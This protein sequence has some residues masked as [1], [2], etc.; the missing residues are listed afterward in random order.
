MRCP[1]LVSRNEE[2]TRL[3]DALALPGSGRGGVWVVR[4]E[5]GVGKSRLAGELLDEARSAGLAVL[6]GRAVRAATPVPLRPLGEALLAWLRAGAV[7]DDPSLA[8]FLPALGRLAPQLRTTAD[9]GEPS[10]VLIGE[11]LLRLATAIGGRGTLLMIEDLH[12]ADPETLNVLQYVADNIRDVPLVVVA[13]TRPHDVAVVT[14]LVSDLHARAALEVV[15]LEPMADDDVTAMLRACLDGEPPA[16]VADLVRRYAAGF[17]LFVEE[18]LADLRDSGALVRREDGWVVGEQPEL[19]VPRSFARSVAGRLEAVSPTARDVLE[20]AA[21]LGTEF[22]WT[23]VGD[24]L[25]LGPRSLSAAMR[26]LRDQRFVVPAPPDGFAFRHALTREAVLES[27]LPPDRVRL[28][29]VLAE[30]IAGTVG[31]TTAGPAGEPDDDAHQ[32]L[33]ELFEAAG[34]DARAATHWLAAGRAAT[35]RG[36]LVSAGEALARAATLVPGDHPTAVE[37][38]EA[39]VGVHALAGDAQAA[40]EVAEPLVARLTESASD[41]AR[42][43]ELQLRLVRILV[44]AGRWDEA[45]ERL[46]ACADHDPALG[47]VL[48]A[49]IALGRLDDDLAGQRARAALAAVGED[50]PEIACEAWEVLGRALRGHDV[51][52]SE[53][54][55]EEGFRIADRHG[56]L[57][58]RARNL[59]QLGSLDIIRRRPTDDRLLAARAALLEIGAVPAAARVDFDIALVRIRLMDVADALARLDRAIAIMRRLRQ[60]ELAIT[61]VLR[62]HAHGLLGDTDAMEADLAEGLALG[63]DDPL[64]TM[65]TAGHVRAPVALARGRY[66]EAHAHFA[67]ADEVLRKHPG[68]PFSMRGLYALLDTVLHDGEAVRAEVRA[69]PQVHAPFNWFAL[70]AADAVAAGRAG[71][72][73]TAEQTFADATGAMP[74]DEPWH[75]LCVWALVARAAAADGWGEP[76]RWFRRA[77][78][79][80]VDLG[81]AEAASATRVAMREAGFAVPRRAAGGDRVPAALQ[82]LGV[83]AREYDVLR[84]VV[85]GRTNKEIADRLFLS[86]RTVETHVARLLQRTGAADRG[87]LGAFAG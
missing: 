57:L 9:D 53:E 48:A 12:W 85:E 22:D 17:P 18:L 41:P 87:G 75:E 25:G 3:R 51:V 49:R 70:G 80:F 36:A 77:L 32:Q 40:L 68:L 46:T 27:V 5:P 69:W 28:A 50:R 14:E 52:A 67:A 39:Q 38:R 56:L 15:D 35:D 7:P 10:V 59:A 6:A 24:A 60:A 79:G 66:D 23:V 8:P 2:L 86:V 61:V 4:G 29:G 19:V 83:T 30:A 13:T 43:A 47:H 37:V 54:A 33:A 65:A 55:F 58:W 82:Q 78:D 31:D 11:A 74:G 62:A 76:E 72:A 45:E 63:A 81:L 84:L 1:V 20:A 44:A 26:E 16:E 64:V 42:L 21:M 73:A 71:D 34:E